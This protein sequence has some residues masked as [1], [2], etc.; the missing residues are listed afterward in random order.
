MKTEQK[1]DLAD[2]IWRGEGDWRDQLRALRERM[3][4]SPRRPREAP[5]DDDK[6]HR[7]E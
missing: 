7:A 6:E 4:G 1:K 2:P 5:K 3:T